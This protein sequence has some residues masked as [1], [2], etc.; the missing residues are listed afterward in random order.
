MYYICLTGSVS[1]KDVDVGGGSGKVRAEQK[2]EPSL[3][4]KEIRRPKREREWI[5][6]M[7]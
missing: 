2:W 5:E 7:A 6:G 1:S 3:Q 4:S